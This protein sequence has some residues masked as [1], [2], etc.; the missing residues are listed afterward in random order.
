MNTTTLNRLTKIAV[1]LYSIL[2][3]V[4]FNIGNS[5]SIPVDITHYLNS[6]Y[7]VAHNHFLEIVDTW[8]GI[9]MLITFLIGAI[10]VF[11]KKLFPLGKWLI[12]IAFILNEVG[13]LIEPAYITYGA[14]Q[15]IIEIYT[16]LEGVILVLLFIPREKSLK[17][18]VP[19]KP[20]SKIEMHDK[21][22]D[23]FG[24]KSILIQAWKIMKMKGSKSAVLLTFLAAA[25]VQLI[26]HFALSKYPVA[27]NSLQFMFFSFFLIPVLTTPFVIGGMLIGTRRCRGEIISNKSGFAYF[28][29][30]SQLAVASI[31]ISSPLLII[32]IFSGHIIVFPMLFLYFIFVLL[33]TFTLLLIADKNI[34]IRSS[35]IETFKMIRL[36]FTIVMLSLL[37][38]VLIFMLYALG[39]VIVFKFPPPIGI[40]FFLA[41]SYWV[42]SYMPLLFGVIYYNLFDKK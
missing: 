30:W 18:E 17:I 12:L 14:S 40:F 42:V 8:F 28:N 35:F 1:I 22:D 25:A 3:A 20:I 19:N 9:I 21:Q 27:H 15:F 41:L 4:S 38:I 26:L 34:T 16:V 31:I 32:K 5:P 37:T 33:S 6:L 2:L 11:F 29:R 36:N 13:S 24:M 23:L 39:V 7:P 10:S